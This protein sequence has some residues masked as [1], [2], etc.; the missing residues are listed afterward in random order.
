MHLNALSKV[1]AGTLVKDAETGEVLA[2]LV[3][4]GDEAIV[5]K[6]GRGGRGNANSPL[7]LIVLLHLL[8]SVNLVKVEHFF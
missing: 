3:N 7:V 6:G 8:N 2:D 4:E 1:P 5:A